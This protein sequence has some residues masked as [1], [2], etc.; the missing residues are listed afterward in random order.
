MN[1]DPLDPRLH[2]C[3]PDLADIRLKGRVKAERFVEGQPYR[4]TAPVVDVRKAPRY[5]SAMISQLICGQDVLVF[6]QQEGFAWVQSE[7]DGYVG[8]INDA[9]LEPRTAALTHRVAVPRTFVYPGADLRLS[10]VIALSMGSRLALVAERET[11]GTCYGLLASGGAVVLAHTKP[12]AAVESDYVSVAEQFVFTPYL[13]GG[14]SGFGLDCS[15]LVQ[16][17]M[18]AGGQQ[19]LRDSDMQ[20]AT[21]GQVIEDIN[22]LRRGDLVFWQGHV[23]IMLDRNTVIH[24]NGSSM[25][26]RAEPLQK[27]CKRMGPH[28]GVPLCL[29][30]PS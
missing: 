11:R 29:R 3:R 7:D 5:D 12:L 17:A 24:A 18:S 16:L 23:A 21:I 9:V 20:A 14:V 10:P 2:A 25:D 27:V 8:Y 6:E 15:G 1:I 13:W 26:V 22:A 30:R 19:V 28:K 4:M